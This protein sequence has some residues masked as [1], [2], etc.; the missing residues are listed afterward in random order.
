MLDKIDSFKIDHNTLTTGIYITRIDNYIN[1]TFIKYTSISITTVDIRITRPNKEPA[2]TTAGIHA[3]E[4]IAATWFRHYHKDKT[5]YFGPMGCRT[6]FYWL[7]FGSFTVDD[8]KPI[9]KQCFEYIANFEGDIPGAS[10]QECG[11]YLDMNLNDAKYYAQILLDN[12]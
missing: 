3:I 12:I 8:V 10:E 5:V 9:I 4:H 6:G 7:L 2:M 1:S 11:N